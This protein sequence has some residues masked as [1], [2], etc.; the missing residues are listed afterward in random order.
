MIVTFI[1]C[2]KRAFPDVLECVALKTLSGACVP[3]F[4]D[5]LGASA[6]SVNSFLPLFIFGICTTWCQSN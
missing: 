6:K 3:P 4:S 2:T 5:A 1:P